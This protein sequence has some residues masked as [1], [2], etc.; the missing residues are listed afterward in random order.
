[1]AIFAN[2]D[3]HSSTCA[4]LGF[5]RGTEKFGD[6]VL[7][8]IELDIKR[9]GNVQIAEQFQ[10]K[11]QDQ[12]SQMLIEMGLGLLSGSTTTQ[13]QTPKWPKRQRCQFNSIGHLWC[14]EQ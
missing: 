9:S 5:K 3:I 7:K 14:T 6:C 13:T 2:F 10:T 11:R 4:D 12:A 1:M 8:L